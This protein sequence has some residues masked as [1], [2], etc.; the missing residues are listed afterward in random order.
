MSLRVLLLAMP[1]DALVLPPTGGPMR[2]GGDD[3][4]QAKAHGSTAMAV[5]R[6]LRWGVDRELADWC[7]SYNRHLAESSGYWCDGSHSFLSDLSRDEPTVYYDS[8]TGK[9]L[10]VAPLG[11]SIQ[12]FLDESKAHG[13]PSFRDEEVVW[14]NVRILG[15]GETVSIDGTHLGHNIPD[16]DGNR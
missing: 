15:D 2:R 9:P 14:D 1:L 6:A 16:A 7:C 8:V 11:R 10:F 4:M 3:L 13:W 5:P 12:S